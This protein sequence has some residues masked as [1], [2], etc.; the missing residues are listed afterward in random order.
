[1]LG[2][3]SAIT[4]SYYIRMTDHGPALLAAAPIGFVQQTPDLSHSPH[5]GRR[6]AAAFDTANKAVGMGLGAKPSRQQGTL[7]PKPETRKPGA[8]Q[9]HTCDAAGPGAR[10]QR[11]MLVPR[12]V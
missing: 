8:R 3:A 12:S 11:V 10:Q 9:H 2:L 7:N 5:D 6:Q 4:S 1:M